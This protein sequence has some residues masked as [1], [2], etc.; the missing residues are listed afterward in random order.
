MSWEFEKNKKHQ[1]PN[2]GK[3]TYVRLLDQNGNL[4]PIEYGKCDRY[5]KCGYKKYPEKEIKID[6]T[7]LNPKYIAKICENNIFRNELFVSLYYTKLF[8]EKKLYKSFEI[9]RVFNIKATKNVFLERYIHS[10]VFFFYDK[11]GKTPLITY[12][13]VIKY[14]GL[15]RSKIIPANSIVNL[16]K[17]V[18]IDDENFKKYLENYEKLEK[19]RKYLFGWH[20][21][22]EYPNAKNI[23]IVESPKTALICTAYYGLPDES[24]S[25]FLAT[26]NSSIDIDLIY[27][28]INRGNKKYN[29]TLIPD[30]SDNNKFYNEWKYKIK[31]I[32]YNKAYILKIAANDDE[33]IADLIIKNKAPDIFSETSYKKLSKTK[34]EIYQGYNDKLEELF[35]EFDLELDEIIGIIDKN[36]L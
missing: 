36:N 23:F 25:I 2:C 30:Y 35:H 19:K 24:N 1:C 17:Y 10:P 34:K 15:N 16:L 12:G 14:N 3:K 18:L 6:D 33:D 32:P 5:L 27:T 7:Y 20:L 8:N 13:Q 9:Y 4:L 28:I 21:L 31:K 26:G 22:K 29:I 11:I